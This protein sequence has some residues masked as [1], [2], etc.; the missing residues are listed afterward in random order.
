MILTVTLNPAI[1]KTYRIEQLMTGQVN[2]I[3]TVENFPGGKGI[4]VSKILHRMGEDVM[5][6][7][8]LGGYA[9][10]YI[11]NA[12]LQKQIGCDFVKVEGETRSSINVLGDDGYVTE[13]LEPGPPIMQ[14]DLDSF[15]L[16]YDV[17]VQK[18]NTVVLSGSVM[19]GVPEDIYGVLIDIAQG[20]KIPVILDTS[21]AY[22]R[23]GIK[24]RPYM[25]KPNRKELELLLGVSL[26]SVEQ[27]ADAARELCAS[28]IHRVVVS[29]GREGMIAADK[30]GVLHAIPPIVDVVNTVGSGDSIVAVYAAGMHRMNRYECIRMAT[31]ISAA[32][33]TTIEN[34][35][36]PMEFAEKIYD[37]VKVREI[38][39]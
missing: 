23:E 22:L 38:C 5:A 12:L 15:L 18:S 39:D 13:L 14:S 17:L 30:T 37:K 35:D 28:G 1:D 19:T 6:I 7:G 31:A 25:I 20:Y 34:G 33:V 36:I 24:Q 4:N 10:N 2:R 32:N 27:V 29:M 3:R 26:R 11:E 8:F 21:G 16:K 9:G